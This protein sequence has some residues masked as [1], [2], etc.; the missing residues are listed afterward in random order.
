MT[1]AN[2]QDKLAE[3]PWMAPRVIMKWMD[4]MWRQGGGWQQWSIDDYDGMWSSMEGDMTVPKVLTRDKEFDGEQYAE[5][6]RDLIQLE[7]E[8]KRQ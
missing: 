5:M 8:K 6:R 1:T 4:A 3:Y 2:V 7:L